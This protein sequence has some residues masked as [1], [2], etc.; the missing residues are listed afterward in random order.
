MGP[1]VLPRIRAETII[2]GRLVGR[3]DHSPWAKENAVAGLYLGGGRFIWGRFTRVDSVETTCEFSPDD[4]NDLLALRPGESYPYVDGYY[5]ERAELVFDSTRTWR[6]SLF[7]PTDSVRYQDSAG[8]WETRARGNTPKCCVRVPGGW[9]HEH[10]SICGMMIG[11]A[12]QHS[13]YVDQS[14]EWVCEKCYR[15]FVGPRSIGFVTWIGGLAVP[16]AASNS[17]HDQRDG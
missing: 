4:P 9:D 12:E 3:S 7:R 8:V 11:A 6:W 5:G 15:E 1:E 10:C 17:A 14:G 16:A 13:G 2:E